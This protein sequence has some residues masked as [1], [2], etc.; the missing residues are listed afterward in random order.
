MKPHL[1]LT[2]MHTA[3]SRPPTLSCMLICTLHEIRKLP[4]HTF[5]FHLA[6]LFVHQCLLQMH[7]MEF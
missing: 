6:L 5:F 2:A 7:K 1:T 3:L 4:P